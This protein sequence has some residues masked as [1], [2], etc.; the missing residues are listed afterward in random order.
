MSDVNTDH[1]ESLIGHI[2]KLL[3][4]HTDLPSGEKKKLTDLRMDCQR[5]LLELS[6]FSKAIDLIQNLLQP[7]VLNQVDFSKSLWD[8]STTV[9][10][11][12]TD[13]LQADHD[14]MTKN[15]TRA[16]VEPFIKSLDTVI[17]DQDILT[18][19]WNKRS[20]LIWPNENQSTYQFNADYTQYLFEVLHIPTDITEVNIA[21]DAISI[22]N[23]KV[24]I[25]YP[26]GL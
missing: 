13:F 26:S 6:L 25:G 14:D 19:M 17:Q 2:D 22:T 18:A 12:L 21:T 7:H 15:I 20:E 9:K 5:S 23:K 16:K 11:R 4:K 10:Q 3:D 1:I 8:L 24:T